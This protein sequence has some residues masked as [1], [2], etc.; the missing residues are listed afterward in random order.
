[1][2]WF[3]EPLITPATAFYCFLALVVIDAIYLILR[4]AMREGSSHDPMAHPYG[5][6]P[7]DGRREP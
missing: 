3:H 5:E 2:N 4:K 1:M 6:M 7:K